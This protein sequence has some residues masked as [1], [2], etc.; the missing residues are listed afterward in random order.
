MAYRSM[1][2]LI[3]SLTSFYYSYH[4]ECYID[5]NREKVDSSYCA[6]PVQASTKRISDGIYRRTGVN[7]R[8]DGLVC[9]PGT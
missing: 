3:Y 4:L 6:D 5:S 1:E 9:L 2:A 7:G 8:L